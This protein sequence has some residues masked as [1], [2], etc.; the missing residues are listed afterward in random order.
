MVI[1]PRTSTSFST[2]LNVIAAVIV[3][4]AIGLTALGLVVIH[5]T[6][7]GLGLA[8]GIALSA[9]GAVAFVLGP[10]LTLIALNTFR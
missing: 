1:A 6:R 8:A 4:I 3:A 2:G 9:A 5:L 10:A 7:G